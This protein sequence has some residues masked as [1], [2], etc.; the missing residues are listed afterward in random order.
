MEF[1]DLANPAIA[2]LIWNP[3]RAYFHFRMRTKL[4][5]EAEHVFGKHKRRSRQPM[6]PSFHPRLINDPFSDP[7]LF[8]PFL[9]EKRAFLFDLG[10]LGGLSNRD[11]LKVSHVFVTHTHM[12]HFIGFDTLLRHFLGRD[13]TLHLFGPPGFFCHVEGK[14]MGYSWNLLNENNHSFIICVHE[15]HQDQVLTKDY[16]CRTR[17]TPPK[18]TIAQKNTFRGILL[19]EPGF[20]IEATLL[21]HRIPCLAFSLVESFHVNIIKEGIKEMGLPL[22]PWLNRLKKALYEKQDR[23]SE[24]TVTWEEAG[25]VIREKRWILGDLAN[26]ITKV[27]PGQ[28][29]TYVTD[30][31]GSAENFQK[32]LKISRG[33]DELFIEAPFLD[34]DKDRAQEKFHLT[35][36]EAGA[37]ARLAGSKRFTLFHFSPRYRGREEEIRKEAMLAFQLPPL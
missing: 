7:G 6:K 13:K 37:L 11:L 32:A 20:H 27:T 33:S 17:F 8:I 12:D 35:A 31:L 25:K 24:F 14:L 19:K 36:S 1:V 30:I 28:K 10:D 3:I 2:G 29:I 26:R 15:V 4:Q 9:F 18:K 34:E 16:G 5:K 23:N 22:G 21:D